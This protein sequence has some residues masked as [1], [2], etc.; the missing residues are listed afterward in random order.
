MA[1]VDN[2]LAYIDQGSFLGLRALGRGPLMQ[3]TWIYDRPVDIDGLRRF[4]RNLGRGL[5]GRRIETSPLPFGRHRWVT[6]PGPADVAIA[7][8]ERSRE[9]VWD[10]ADERVCVPIDP[11]WGPAWHIGVQPLIE[12]GAAVTM[13]ASHSVADALGMSLAIRDAVLDETW[14]LGYPPAGSRSRR[15][16]LSEDARATMRALPDA[17]RAATAS[18]RIAR[19]ES[20]DVAMSIR[21]TGAKPTTADDH[22][23]V[24]PTIAA[25]FDIDE[26]DRRADALGGTSNSLFAGLAARL[27]QLVGRTDKGGR[28]NL[29]WPVSERTE[30]DTRAN[31]LTAVMVNVDPDM[32]PSNLSAIRAEMKSALSALD[33][34]SK[35]LMAPLPLV[36]FTPRRLVRRL[37]M[38]VGS[39]GHPTGCSN[40]GDLHPAVNRPDGTDADHISFRLLE[41]QITTGILDR[42]GGYVYLA[43]GRVHDQIFVTVGAWIVGSP[44]T[45]QS[46]RAVFER[47]IDDM[48]LSGI[49]ERAASQSASSD[50]PGAP[51]PR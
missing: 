46:L 39:V 28:V 42:M 45:K 5:L 23:V 44:N 48:K 30:G 4:Q 10:W 3:F 38:M 41:P 11:Q 47:A 36:P 20:G 34:T 9:Q 19:A 16:A 43:S 1:P 40:L 7:A 17:A 37:E 2:T 50:G 35:K 31:A 18:I 24:A 49:V 32:A 29:S 22:P 26:W 15:R 21:T 25:Y 8:A 27:S 12:G 6:S 33:E 51:R 14:D 13:V